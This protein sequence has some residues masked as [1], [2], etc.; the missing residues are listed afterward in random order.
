MTEQ[1]HDEAEGQGW[2]VFEVERSDESEVMKLGDV[3]WD[4]NYQVRNLWDTLDEKGSVELRRV[5][6]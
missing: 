2:S 1:E 5:R 3:F 6:D 4:A